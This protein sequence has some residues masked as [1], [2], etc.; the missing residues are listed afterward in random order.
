QRSMAAITTPLLASAWKNKDFKKIIELYQKTSITLL[1]AAL[2]IF[3][4]IWTNM[5]MIMHFSQKGYGD[6][7][8]LI[9]ILGIAKVIDLGTGVN[10]QIIQTSNFWKFDFFTTIIFITLSIP[11]NYYMIK[12]MGIH[13]AAYTNLIALTVYNLVRFSFIWVKFNI[14]PFTQKTLLILGWTF[15]IYLIFKIL[16]VWPNLYLNFFIRNAILIPS[17]CFG[18]IF[19]KISQDI[20][21]IY[22]Q[23]YSR[24]KRVIFRT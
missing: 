13:G 16:P 2:F 23:T 5:D 18:I 17:F 15:L 9:L 3:G 6:I 8:F 22:R 20:D 4:L 12:T 14:Q 19:M 7:E 21:D 10:N 11:L 24:L 1:I